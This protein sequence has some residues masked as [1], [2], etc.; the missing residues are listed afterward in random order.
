MDLNT[1]KKDTEITISDG[2]E[3]PQNLFDLQHEV[4]E[5]RNRK[6]YFQRFNEE[7]QEI[8]ISA[9]PSYSDKIDIEYELSIKNLT[10]KTIN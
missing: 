2:S 3:D 9:L 5:V 6:G 1:L 4:W 10:I 8:T 7:T